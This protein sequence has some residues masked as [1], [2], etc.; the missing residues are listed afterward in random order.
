MRVLVCGSRTMLWTYANLMLVAEALSAA[1]PT[2]IIEGGA[3]GAD[4]IGKACG[5]AVGIP[6]LSRPISALER[7]VLKKAAGR[8]RNQRMLAD[9]PDLV[10]AFHPTTGCTPGTLDMITRARAAGVP[11]KVATYEVLVLDNPDEGTR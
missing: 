10:L 5:K 9:K 8:A 1:A 4:A 11:V 6:V 7:K 3:T 2:L